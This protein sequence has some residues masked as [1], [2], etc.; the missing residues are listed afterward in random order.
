MRVAFNPDQETTSIQRPIAQP[1]TGSVVP[2]SQ[3]TYDWRDGRIIMDTPF[4]KALLG[5]NMG[6][7]YVFKDGIAMGTTN[8]DYTNFVLVSRDGRPL[9]SS[10][11]AVLSVVSTAEN[12]QVAQAP[13]CIWLPNNWPPTLAHG[14]QFVW[15]L[16]G[17]VVVDRVGTEVSFP[18]RVTA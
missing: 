16:D 12:D 6:Q 17:T 8:T 3:I 10:N 5:F 15:N 7:G 13:G 4:V 11:D 1:T 9:E 14:R 2:F 18:R